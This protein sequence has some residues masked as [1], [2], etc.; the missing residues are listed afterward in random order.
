MRYE[1][2]ADGWPL[3]PHCGKDELWSPLIPN[4][5]DSKPPV[6]AYI[7]AG[8]RCYRCGWAS[9]DQVKQ[10]QAMFRIAIAQ[11]ESR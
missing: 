4:P 6:S 8:L 9:D 2:R 7:E 3:C 10:S 1:T 11:P 5:I